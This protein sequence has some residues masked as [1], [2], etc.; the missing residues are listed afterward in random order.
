MLSWISKLAKK[1]FPGT[2]I[3]LT[4]RD[5]LKELYYINIVRILRFLPLVTIILLPI[6]YI[7]Y[8]RVQGSSGVI[9]F[10]AQ[11]ILYAHIAFLS[12]MFVAMIVGRFNRPGSAADINSKHILV[13]NFVIFLFLF[14]MA[15]VSYG[16][17]IIGS[18]IT[19]FTSVV[20][21]SAI[22]FL[23]PHGIS[24]VLYTVSSSILIFA[25]SQ[26]EIVPINALSHYIN[27]V[28]FVLVAFIISRYLYHIQIRDFIH[29]REK[30][31]F[32]SIIAHDLRAPFNSLIGFS[33]TMI[34]DFDN[35]DDSVKKEIIESIRDV[36]T[37]TF[38]LLENLLNWSRS[39]TG[40]LELKKENHIVS[41]LIDETMELQGRV[42]AEKSITLSLKVT[43]GATVFADKN[44]ISTCLRNLMSNAIKFTESRGNILVSTSSEKDF[45]LIQIRDD[46]VG[47]DERAID[48]LFRI[49]KKQST[50]GTNREKGSG[51][52][53]MLCKE[54]VELNSGTLRVS[55]EPGKGSTFTIALPSRAII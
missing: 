54:F 48:N 7:D 17:V 22:L 36:S 34:D 47:M 35:L 9:M 18:S 20:F 19:N 14:S 55:S 39:Q 1:R 28:V 41:D 49:D 12:I 26:L 30:D 38:Q 24:L 6:I 46:G 23:I 37:E 43:K 11:V 8:A 10:G 40:A 5:M 50:L 15:A 42:A 52:G 16:D 29:L 31:R 32:Y 13:T 4:E 51:L 2:S 53:L 44:T 21:I 45:T 27:L 33:D 3:F 25:I